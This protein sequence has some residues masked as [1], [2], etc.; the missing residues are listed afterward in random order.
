MSDCT[1]PEGQTIRDE[2][3]IT[4][5]RVGSKGWSVFRGPRNVESNLTK[6]GAERIASLLNEHDALKAVAEAAEEAAMCH[7]S[8]EVW[9][10]EERLAALRLLVKEVSDETD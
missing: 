8:P 4:V 2:T 10:L 1:R 5:M 7:S 6:H 3:T 9:K